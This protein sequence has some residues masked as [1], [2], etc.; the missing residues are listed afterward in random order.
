MLEKRQELEEHWESVTQT[1][2]NTYKDQVEN[3]IGSIEH[4][5]TSGEYDVYR[6]ENRNYECVSSSMFRMTRPLAQLIERFPQLV[7]ETHTLTSLCNIDGSRKELAVRIHSMNSNEFE[8][9]GYFRF[10]FIGNNYGNPDLLMEA[11][12][13]NLSRISI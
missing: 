5:R 9:M 13:R 11:A 6:G 12:E 4:I 8:N 10:R 7:S 2:N 1:V 3:I